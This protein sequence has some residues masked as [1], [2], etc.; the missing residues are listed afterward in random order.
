MAAFEVCGGISLQGEIKI[1][2]SKNA[3]LPILA[4]TVLHKGITK[5]YHCPKILDVFHMIS[6]M[7]GIGCQIEE[8]GEA[9]VIDA[10]NVTTSI[11]DDVY[12]STLRSSVVLAGALLGRCRSVT[13]PYPGGCTI[14]RRPL[15][16]HVQ[17]FR[18][19]GC[20]VC[21]D[22]HAI[23]CKAKN[24]SGHD[25]I[26]R[27]PSVGATENAILASVKING[28]THIKGAAK[29]PEIIDLCHFLNH[30]G[31]DI[32]GMGTENIYI[33]GVSEFRDSTYTIDFDRIVAGTYLI[34]SAA[35]YGNLWLQHVCEKQMASILNVCMHMGCGLVVGNDY[36]QMI[37]PPLLMPIPKLHTA[38]FPG[39]PT[40]MQSQLIA[41]LTRASGQSMI[42]EDI[43][44]DRFKMIEELLNMGA[45]IDVEQN[46]AIIYGPCRLHGTEVWAK[47]LR[48]GAALIIAG[49]MAEGKTKIYHGEYVDRGYEDICKDLQQ[50]GADITRIEDR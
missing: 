37:A 6:I 15:D 44:E 46:K 48:G 49:L 5:L 35:T 28:M 24:M 26:F 32:R 14:G 29:E 22:E 27:Y 4:A 38:P 3:A 45:R 13:L 33:Y 19:L 11:L 9:L 47:D 2:G 34:A 1:Q 18:D 20:E 36:I 30:M 7:E 31:A 42:F 40:D 23:I 17:A 41:A 21:E 25:I 16:L 8:D 39:F 12:V 50:L 10:A 43:F